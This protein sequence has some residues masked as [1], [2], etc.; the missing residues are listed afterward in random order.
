MVHQGVD[1]VYNRIEKRFEWP[2]SKKACEKWTAA[3]LSSQQAKDPRKLRFPFQSIESSG[4][5][6]VVQI[7]HQKTCITATGYNQ[8][9]VMI[10]H[11]TKYAEA[12][13]CMTGS[14]EE[15]CDHLINVLIARHGCPITF[16]SDNGKAIVDDLTKE[17]MKKSHVAQAHSTNYHSQTNG[18]VERQNRT[19]VSML[20]VYCSRYMD[21]W[22]RHLPQVMGAHISIE[23]SNTEISP[24]MMLTGHE[25]ALSLTLFYPEYEEGK[26]HRK[27]ACMM[28][29]KG[30]RVSRKY[31]GG[32]CNRR[33]SEKKEI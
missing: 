13:P 27:P 30:S 9:L 32:T 16:E 17:L 26:Q 31:A 29:L 11:F 5:N 1:R 21:D 12:A 14:A 28:L 25:K 4:F 24:H 18:L 22:D 20:R 23:H 2:G 7:D 6:E 10:N 3:C 19:L 8:V 15:K 33:K